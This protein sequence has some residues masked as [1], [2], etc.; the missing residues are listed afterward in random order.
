M[1]VPVSERLV[2]SQT[3]EGLFLRALKPQLTERMKDRI[4]KEAGIDLR[5]P[6]EPGYAMKSWDTAVAIAAEELHPGVE[7]SVAFE[8]LGA[9]LTQGYFDTMIGSAMA[10]M[11]RLIGPS[12]AIRRIER[13][14][15]SGNN[16]T[17]SSLTELSPSH[18]EIHTNEVGRLRDNLCG[19]IRRGMEVAGAKNV[20]CTVLRFDDAGAVYDIEWDP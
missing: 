5:A 8:R 10:A 14:V 17:E 1:S 20:R 15:R 16:Y 6:L 4:A 19:V 2:F 18:F 12:R 9:A 13:S 3:V 7:L 11:L